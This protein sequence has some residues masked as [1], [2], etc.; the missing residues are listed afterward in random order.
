MF[1]HSGNFR[2]FPFLPT[3]GCPPPN[4]VPGRGGWR[5]T[6]RGHPLGPVSIRATVAVRVKLLAGER[7]LQALAAIAPATRGWVVLDLSQVIGVRPSVRQLPAAVL[8]RI[9]AAGH[10]VGLVGDVSEE[11]AQVAVV[12][13][14]R[15]EALVCRGEGLLMN[16]W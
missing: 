15:D 3:A 14:T 1:N 16:A 10:Q 11:A 2:Y 13:G 6:Q 7:L 9:T 5:R 8:E 12:H 4:R